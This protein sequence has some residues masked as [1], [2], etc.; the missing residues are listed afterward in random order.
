MVLQVQQ[1]K[2]L[3]KVKSAMIFPNFGLI[4]SAM[5]SVTALLFR[6]LHLLWQALNPESPTIS[7]SCRVLSQRT[8]V[9][10]YTL[11]VLLSSTQ[12]SYSPIQT[13]YNCRNRYGKWNHLQHLPLFHMDAVPCIV[14]I[15][16]PRY[17]PP[18]R[19]GH[20]DGV[21]H[22]PVKK[23]PLPETGHRIASNS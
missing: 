3:P 23:I 14:Q 7:G 22:K 4:I 11:W 9:R 6:T 10:I 1:Q 2:M 8:C 19:Q 12:N 13:T 16:R 17:D 21:N 15:F 20:P 5:K 18:V